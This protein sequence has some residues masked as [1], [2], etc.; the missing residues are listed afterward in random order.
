MVI[1]ESIA[2]LLRTGNDDID[3]IEEEEEEQQ[4]TIMGSGGSAANLSTYSFRSQKK[5]KKR[6]AYFLKYQGSNDIYRLILIL[7]ITR[8]SEITIRN[9]MLNIFY[10]F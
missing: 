7:L 6:F 8:A 2:D 4:K 10:R 3:K 9:G 5:K 1:G